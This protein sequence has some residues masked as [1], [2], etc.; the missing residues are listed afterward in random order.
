MYKLTILL[1]TLVLSQNTIA[2][3]KFSCKL[4]STV[5]YSGTFIGT[6]ERWSQDEYLLDYQLKAKMNCNH[7]GNCLYELDADAKGLRNRTSYRPTKNLDYNQ[8]ILPMSVS[9]SKLSRSRVFQVLMPK[10]PAETFTAMLIYNES[11]GRYRSKLN[12]DCTLRGEVSRNLPQNLDLNDTL[13][14]ARKILHENFDLENTELHMDEEFL[15]K[16]L[17]QQSSSAFLKA[18]K[19]ALISILSNEDHVESPIALGRIG[20][21]EDWNVG[22]AKDSLLDYNVSRWYLKESMKE[23]SSIYFDEGVYPP[24]NGESPNTN[25]IFRL[26]VENLS[27]HIYWTIAPKDGSEIY[28]YG[29]N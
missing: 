13:E 10:D 6:L 15:E 25:W 22:G 7:H 5:A 3:D 18:F 1:A 26:Q 12:M 29:F 4:D 27:D 14:H 21:Y 16:Q 23:H 19:G 28:N 9:N 24:E 8:F 2:A 17:Q 11:N 20:A